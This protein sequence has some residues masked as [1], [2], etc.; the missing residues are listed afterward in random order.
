M[1]NREKMGRTFAFAKFGGGGGIHFSNMRR[2]IILCE[3]RAVSLTNISFC[4]LGISKLSPAK[5]H[6][7]A[8]NLQSGAS[9]KD[10]RGDNLKTWFISV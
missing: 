2:A 4:R 10:R 8:P 3:H 9:N 7:L 1:G 5:F 6:G